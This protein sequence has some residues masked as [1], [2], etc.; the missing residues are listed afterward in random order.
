MRSVRLT[1]VLFFA[2]GLAR[3]ADREEPRAENRI[4]EEAI[5]RLQEISA[6]LE[7][8][9]ST[10]ERRR[11]CKR[12]VRAAES[13]LRKHR[14]SPDRFRALGV[15]FEA[16]KAMFSMRQSDEYRE[17]LLETA[18]R[19]LRAPDG[20]AE[21]R[22]EPDMM[23]LQLR[24]ADERRSADDGALEIARFADRY[25][26]TPAEARS[27]M[28]AAESAFD[29]GNA[30]LL[31]AF[32]RT[33]AARFRDDPL[34]VAFMRERFATG[35][36]VH[37]D[38]E[39]ERANGRAISFPVGRTYV[40]CFWS[41]DTP[42]LKER[43]A[44]IASLQK[45]YKGRF[46][47]F[48][49]NL[50]E[51]ADA[52]KGALRRM[53]LDWVPVR[54]PDG[55][56]N[57]TYLSVGGA[58][59]FSALVVGPHGLASTYSTRHRPAPLHK[60]YEAA[61]E[62]PGR[63]ALLRSLSTGEFLLSD[64]PVPDGAGIPADALHRIRECFPP[65][66]MRHRLTPEKEMD[67]YRKAE[68]LCGDVLAKH[69]DAPGLWVVHNCRTIALLG[70]WRLLGDS[71]YLAHAVRSA[72][73]ALAYDLPPAASTVPHF[74][75]A[76][77]RIAAGGA[78][79]ERILADFIE[80]CGG[81]KPPPKAHAAALMLSL[82]AHSRELYAKCRHR[83][84]YDHVYDPSTWRVSSFLLDR[85]TSTRLFG[86]AFP[87]GTY[88]IDSPRGPDRSLA[89]DWPKVGGGRLD[90]SSRAGGT[91]NA[92]VFMERARDRN[93]AALQKRVV[94]HLIRTAGARSRKDLAVTR[95]F[96][97]ND[98]NGAA[99]LM[100]RNKW[101]CEAVCLPE[102]EWRRCALEIGVFSA[103]LRPNV[104]LVRPDGTI[105]LALSGVG[106]DSERA[107]TIAARIDAALRE[108]DLALAE[109]AL[110]RRDYS[111]YAAR[112]STSFPLKNRRR[113][114]HEPDWHATSKHRRKLVWAYMK[115]GDWKSALREVN[116]NIAIHL[117]KHVTKD[118]SKRSEHVWCRTCYGPVFGMFIR[119][120]LLQELGREKEAA[121]ALRQAQAVRCPE[122]KDLKGLW[123]EVEAYMA[124]RREHRRWRHW[125][126]P[127]RFLADQERSMRAGRQ[128]LFDF[129]V[130]HD[131]MMRSRIH[132]AMGNAGA[133][134][135]D[136]RHA[137]LYEWPFKIREYD[138]DLTHEA[139]VR[140]R[141]LA[142]EHLEA[143]EW[144]E[145]FELADT[146]IRLHEAEP[147]RCNG[148]CWICDTQVQNFTWYAR[149][150]KGLGRTRE[151]E[152]ALAMAEDARCPPGEAR[153]ST[154]RFPVNRMYGGGSGKNRLR[155]IEGIMKGEGY[156]DRRAREYR[157]EFASDLVIR[158][159]ALEGLGEAQGA[160][161]DRRRATALAYPYGPNSVGI[162]DA[163]PSRYIDL[164]GPAEDT[165]DEADGASGDG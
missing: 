76:T 84:V 129:G 68:K 153:E 141:R 16:Q 60:R 133:A 72:R 131:L 29:L 116:A 138:L 40:V 30:I 69:P 121:E 27:L 140:R 139:T 28:M 61:A 92:L 137:E 97:G 3:A 11:A 126:D 113:S 70:M 20:H 165:G 10:S 48:S 102:A 4:P 6:A 151:A 38:G 87:G 73:D 59:L 9:E 89:V 44:E 112:L 13:L 75:L 125:I 66:P 21:L 117:G 130:Q 96:R 79:A 43:V 90:T 104:F 19:L 163:L 35:S 161:R 98:T 67:N 58:N 54:L 1:M 155:F 114:R 108:H 62:S 143:G 105:M 122:T 119:V 17:A 71:E 46:R 12:I 144:K 124:S 24:L 100:A 158:S 156:A 37:L 95:I 107:E 142:R 118:P 94:D 128:K 159:R 57:P 134:E 56:A 52:G 5:T 7:T 2:T 55:A 148:A 51:Q 42:L 109:A 99:D 160:E 157:L 45:R 25:R 106:A 146:N 80:A 93:A 86:K 36:E 120:R 135:A 164:L 74:S 123:A 50:D 33:L 8:I 83:L 111:E 132:E 14:D 47:V 149:T 162:E 147:L 127:K 26:D 32:R 145:A 103:D 34:V 91:I 63:L 18:Q 154:K 39:F 49:F 88:D 41:L 136:R 115:A 150:L 85:S 81:A 101:S 53:G 22:V 23:L 110:E 82:D 31:G 15:I 77:K 152:A 65:P 78:D 64:T